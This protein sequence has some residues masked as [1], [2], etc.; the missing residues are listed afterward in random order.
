MLWTHRDISCDDR[1]A[2]LVSII[3]FEH[4]CIS[5][6]YIYTGWAASLL[7][8]G[9][10][11][12]MVVPHPRC[13]QVVGREHSYWTPTRTRKSRIEFPSWHEVN[14][15]HWYNLFGVCTLNIVHQI[16][17]PRMWQRYFYVCLDSKRRKSRSFT[18]LFMSP[19]S[20]LHQFPAVNSH[21]QVIAWS[22]V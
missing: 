1:N 19:I 5:K 16:F 13:S 15:L 6:A 11:M 7:Q 8:L 4:L 22:F 18:R 20:N 9:T 14:E 10:D 21:F 17:L 2:S 3:S 12:G